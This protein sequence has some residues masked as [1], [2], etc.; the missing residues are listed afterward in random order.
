[1]DQWIS[2]VAIFLW[3]L[4]SAVI[5]IFRHWIIAWVSAGVQHRF[6]IKIEEVRTE[7]RKAEANFN[8]L[9][10][11]REAEIAALRNSVLSGSFSRQAMLDKRR[12]EAVEKVWAAVNDLA[13]L[14]SLSAW[15]AVL[16][17]KAM[18]Q[19]I[20]NPKMQQFLSVVGAS[21]P[22]PKSLK[23]IARDE[24]PF[25]P[26]LAWAYFSAY[27]TIL[28]GGLQR[29]SAL[30]NGLDPNRY[31]KN[32]VTQSILKAALPHQSQFI[33]EQEPES[34][35]HLLEEIEV[36]LLMELRK[37]LEAK[38]ADQADTA[39]AKEI[40]DAISKADTARTQEAAGALGKGE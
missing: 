14:K 29:Y 40:M 23:N 30:K 17:V 22:D 37:I 8:G 33:D 3:L 25:L 26:E 35:Y 39:R 11:N 20:G 24:R 31:L 10:R 38:D 28:Y 7:L 2:S 16:N 9:L 15:M 13:L 34:Y 21:A 19:D 1:M 5:F 18:A 36:S 32:E 6:D 27:T 4:A 12:F